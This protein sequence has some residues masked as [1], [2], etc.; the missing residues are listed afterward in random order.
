M[1]TIYWLKDV[2]A[3][4]VDHERGYGRSNVIDAEWGVLSLLWSDD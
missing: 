3:M 2:D 4:L 1:S